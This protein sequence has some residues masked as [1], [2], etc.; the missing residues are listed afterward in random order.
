MVLSFC[1]QGPISTCR[2]FDFTITFENM[3]VLVPSGLLILLA[4]SQMSILTNKP[5]LIQQRKSLF[6][7]RIWRHLDLVGLIRCSL[8]LIHAI[9]AVAMLGLVADDKRLKQVLVPTTIIP[10]LVLSMLSALL[11]VPFSYLARLKLPNGSY[12]LSI[13]L[14]SATLIDACRVRTYLDIPMMR[15]SL[16][17]HLSIVLM[18]FKAL[19]FVAEN[20]SGI[21]TMQPTTGGSASFLS[22]MLFWWLKDVIWT[23]FRRPLE[24]VN[25]QNLDAAFEG[26]MLGARISAIWRD[27]SDRS[28]EKRGFTSKL[29]TLF[30]RQRSSTTDRSQDQQIAED[31]IE[32]DQLNNLPAKEDEPSVSEEE[33]QINLLWVCFKSFPLAL[34]EPVFP[35][36]CMTGATLALPFLVRDTLAFAES[37]TEGNTAQ[38]TVYGWGLVGAY[39]LVYLVLAFSTGQFYWACDKGLIK[40]RGALLDMI[41][42]KCLRLHLNSARTAG[43]GAA[44]NLMA[45]DLERFGR[46]L[47]EWRSY[48][49]HCHLS[50]LP[51]AW[52]NFH[53]L[54][55][56][57]HLMPGVSAHC[58]Q[59]CW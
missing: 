45:V 59:R 34:L 13:Y 53:C 8:A 23:G 25:L 22:T 52:L 51:A 29:K 6:Q 16:Y 7:S 50:P 56:K 44:A 40:I 20:T 24:M 54:A 41:Y 57:C 5:I 30:R 33:K 27:Q 49:N 3:L 15:Q 35:K 19:M 48:F 58:K 26:R 9:I 2:F 37:H 32:M 10:A 18:A 21:R 31:S 28:K 12:I 4:I 55:R 38:P 14:F 39:A 36:L 1:C 11:I 46:Y 42:R 43:G 17:T 47:L